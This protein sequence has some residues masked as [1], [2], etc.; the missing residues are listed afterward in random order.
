[1]QAWGQRQGSRCCASQGGATRRRAGNEERCERATRAD[2]AQRYTE[3][4]HA[5][6]DARTSHN[7]HEPARTAARA[8]CCPK[9]GSETPPCPACDASKAIDENQINATARS[10][11]PTN[12]DSKPATACN[13][14]MGQAN[15]RT[16]AWVDATTM[17]SN[18]IKAQNKS[19]PDEVLARRLL[20]VRERPHGVPVA[21]SKSQT[22]SE[23][24]LQ[25]SDFK[26]ARRAS[27]N[28]ASESRGNQQ[29]RGGQVHAG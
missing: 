4:E 9:S 12:D 22:G 25:S 15:S 19:S 10:E 21:T 26:G 23:N 24:H 29:K 18:P 1:M 6:N 3:S 16:S 14:Q 13:A 20:P 11:C 8:R 28:E 7:T 17:N 5:A 27:S 2:P